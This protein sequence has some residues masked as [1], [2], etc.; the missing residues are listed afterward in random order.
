MYTYSGLIQTLLS[1]KNPWYL[2]SLL[3]VYVLCVTSCIIR[4]QITKTHNT[5][6][7]EI[8]ICVHEHLLMRN[9]IIFTVLRSHSTF[10]I[11][12]KYKSKKVS[13]LSVNNLKNVFFCLTFSWAIFL[14]WNAREGVVP[15]QYSYDRYYINNNIIYKCC[16]FLCWSYEL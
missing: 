10:H 14:V 5:L 2:T 3:D 12:F 7:W 4:R 13:F 1:Q 9:Q 6:V 8:I 15:S 11:V 16:I